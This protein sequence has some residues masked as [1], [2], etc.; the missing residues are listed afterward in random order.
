[1]FIF[2]ADGAEVGSLEKAG[3]ISYRNPVTIGDDLVYQ[4]WGEDGPL[5]QDVTVDGKVDRQMVID[6][7]STKDKN[8]KEIET[9]R[10][11]T[12]ETI[13]GYEKEYE[14]ALRLDKS[15]NIYS[16]K[17]RAATIREYEAKV[18]AEQQRAEKAIQKL[19]T[20]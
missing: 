7:I 15:G 19:E 8:D 3:D 10:E 18:S 2:G 11:E 17:Q 5:M 20:P 4:V 14:T 1:M 6:R 12:A 16:R 9:I 13:K